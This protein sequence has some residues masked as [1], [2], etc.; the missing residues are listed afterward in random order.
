MELNEVTEIYDERDLPVEDPSDSRGESDEQQEPSHAQYDLLTYPA[1]FT[2]EVLD[3]KFSKN[4]D[5]VIP[6]F[7]R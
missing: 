7:Q 5:I 3:Q 6:T 1:D 2:L 4:K